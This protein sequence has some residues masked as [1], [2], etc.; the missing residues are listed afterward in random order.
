MYSQSLCSSSIGCLT[1][2]E[3]VGFHSLIRCFTSVKYGLKPF[4]SIMVQGISVNNRNVT[5][6]LMQINE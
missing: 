3:C 4:F 6:D 1:E 2:Q 5:K